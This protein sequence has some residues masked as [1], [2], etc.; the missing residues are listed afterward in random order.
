MKNIFFIGFMLAG[1]NSQSQSIQET[2][3]YIIQQHN[4]YERSINSDNDLIIENGIVFYK[5]TL[6]DNYGFWHQFPLKNIK[7]IDITKEFYDSEGTISWVSI[8][9][10]F[11]PYVS[12]IKDFDDSKPIGDFYNSDTP[13]CYV[14]L[15]SRFMDDG[16]APAMEEA[17]IRLIT[18]SGRSAEII[19]EPY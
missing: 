16:I 6:G 3:D 18:L 8:W 5:M 15:D 9:L 12:K 19:S 4:Q 17:L 13:G 7:G 2:T 10:Y 14:L 1:I 11:D